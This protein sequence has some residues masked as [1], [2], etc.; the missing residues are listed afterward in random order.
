MNTILVVDDSPAAMHGIALDDLPDGVFVTDPGGTIRQ[1]NAAFLDLIERRPC[2]VAG[3]L[4]TSLLAPEDLIT[5]VGFE[6]V[7]GRGRVQDA[8]V[9]FSLPGGA[10]RSLLLCSAPSHDASR[11]TFAARECASLNQELSDISRWAAEEQQRAGQLARA[12]DELAN[13]NQALERARQELQTAYERVKSESEARERLED[14]LRLAQKLE[15]IG[16]LAAGVAHEINTPM[17]YIGNNIDFL[18]KGFGA[19]VAYVAQVQ[20]IVE[21]AEPVSLDASKAKLRK[22]RR[23]A[24]LEFLMNQIPSALEESSGG[25]EHV[26][27]IVRAMKS[28]TRMDESEKTV[29]D[30]NQAIRDALAVAQSEYKSV[31]T[32]VT[33]L[34]EIPPVLCFISKLNQVFLNLIVNAAHAIADRRSPQLGTITVRSR[35]AENQVEVEFE[36]TGCGIPPEIREKIFDQ[37]FTTKAVGRGTGQGLALVRNVVVGAHG[38]SID[39]RSQIGVGSTFILRLPLETG[40]L[41]EPSRRGA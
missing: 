38:G 24:K 12:R 3:Q 9:I 19:I 25:V 7:F 14:E 37:F 30:V 31:A 13:K 36:D 40:N 17:Q 20:T 41:A 39:L 11:L 18:R 16:Q 21:A 15:A 26:S 27:R 5:I 6:A 35:L 4:L 10:T 23:A 22:A 34:A 1:A 33:D 32:I 8:S 2:D 29:S 28:F